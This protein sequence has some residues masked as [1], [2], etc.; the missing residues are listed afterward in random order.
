MPVRDIIIIIIHFSACLLILSLSS[1]SG[2]D[3]HLTV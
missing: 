2:N 3:G 1:C